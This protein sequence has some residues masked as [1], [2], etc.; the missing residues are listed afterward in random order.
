MFQHPDF[1]DEEL[2][3]VARYCRVLGPCSEIFRESTELIEGVEDNVPVV[4]EGLDQIELLQNL[5]GNLRE[6]IA[7][8]TLYGFEV[9]D[10]NK[11]AEENIPAPTQTTGQ[12]MCQH[13]K[14]R[15]TFKIS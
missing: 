7:Q 3:V 10:D 5:T 9:D 6:D 4:D 14:S 13:N 1:D 8:L 11:P 15:P 12:S 2:Y